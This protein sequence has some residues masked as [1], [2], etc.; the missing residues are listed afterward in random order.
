M[1][2]SSS[3]KLDRGEHPIGNG[4]EGGEDV[5]AAPITEHQ[6]IA[7]LCGELHQCTEGSAG[8]DNAATKTFSNLLEGARCGDGYGNGSATMSLHDQRRHGGHGT[9]RVQA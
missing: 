7:L 3:M 5:G 4:V 2:V 1:T 8:A 6:Q 9:E